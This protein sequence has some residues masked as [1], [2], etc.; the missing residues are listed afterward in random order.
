MPETFFYGAKKL[1]SGIVIGVGFF[2]QQYSDDMG[3]VVA[4]HDD[5][6]DDEDDDS[7][8]GGWKM[9]GLQNGM[10]RL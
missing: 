5:E 2:H 10:I 3:D 9:M 1:F 7:D 6:D 8:D 4:G